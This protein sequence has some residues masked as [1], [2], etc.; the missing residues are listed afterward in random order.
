MYG[1]V[2]DF[3]KERGRYTVQLDGPRGGQKVNLKHNNLRHFGPQFS[4]M[5][6][7]DWEDPPVTAT[8]ELVDGRMVIKKTPAATDG[9]YARWQENRE[10]KALELKLPAAVACSSSSSLQ[11]WQRD[12]AN[13]ESAEHEAALANELRDRKEVEL[14][15]ISDCHFA[16][17]LSQF[18]SDFI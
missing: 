10:E 1:T 14:R 6:D 12:R 4:E 11:Q 16:E 9:S 15:A 5:D 2:V 7:P 18:I 8:V 17:Q 13:R 3:V